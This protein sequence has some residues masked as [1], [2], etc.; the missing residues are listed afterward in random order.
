MKFFLASAFFGLVIVATCSGCGNSSQGASSND[1]NVMFLNITIDG[2]DDPQRLDMALK[3]AG[4]ALEEKRDVF[5]FFNVKGVN[6]P[7]KAF[8]ADRKFG[9]DKNAT[10]K[11][12]LEKLI[13]DGAVVHVCPICMEAIGLK[14]EDL[15]DGAEVTTKSGLFKKIGGNTAVF[16]Y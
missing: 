14:K 6:V 11:K 12:Q 1:P 7:S 15:I 4:F 8:P 13:A 2:S 16:T 10:L 9:G 5:I 3:L